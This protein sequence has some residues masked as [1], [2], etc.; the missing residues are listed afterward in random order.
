MKY[1]WIVVVA[2]MIIISIFMFIIKRLINKDSSTDVSVMMIIAGVSL[3]LSAFRGIKETLVAIAAL[4]FK[5]EIE[6][7]TD[8]VAIV[9]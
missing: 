5:V 1:Y 8:N 6:I 9:C 4:L 2:A 7:A 3:I